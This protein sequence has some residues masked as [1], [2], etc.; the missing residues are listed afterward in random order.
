MNKEKDGQLNQL[1]LRNSIVC[2]YSIKPRN[3]RINI[4]RTIMQYQSQITTVGIMKLIQ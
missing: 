1:Q 2:S 4:S 3:R